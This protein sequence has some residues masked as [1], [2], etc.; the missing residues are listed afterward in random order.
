MKLLAIDGNSMKR[1][2]EKKFPDKKK[3]R[4]VWKFLSSRSLTFWFCAHKILL[5]VYMLLFFL[6]LSPQEK[7]LWQDPNAPLRYEND[8][9]LYA[10]ESYHY[11]IFTMEGTVFRILLRLL[12]VSV[13]QFIVFALIC[14]AWVMSARAYK[15]AVTDIDRKRNYLSDGRNILDIVL[16]L[17]AVFSFLR[18]SAA[19]NFSYL[20]ADRSDC[21]FFSKAALAIGILNDE[22]DSIIQTDTVNIGLDELVF[23]ENTIYYSKADVSPLA[24]SIPVP[25]G[26]EF[27]VWWEPDEGMPVETLSDC[28]RADFDKAKSHTRTLYS[29][30][31]GDI[32]IPLSKSDYWWIRDNTDDYI[33]KGYG[34]KMEYYRHSHLLYRFT[35]EKEA[36]S[37]E[38]SLNMRLF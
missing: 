12:A 1:V 29:I 23:A 5:V 8:P 37:P 2:K 4:V 21:N 28:I 7:G 26:N 22:K 27:S 17:T 13:L 20:S 10:Y 35:I 14:F 16:N 6:N 34:V 18:C 24:W 19:V 25:F 31:C 11:H 15:L 38:K 32:S 33:G 36:D 30:K 9:V 3:C